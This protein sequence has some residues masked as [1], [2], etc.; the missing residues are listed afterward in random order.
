[1]EIEWRLMLK[2]IH[3]FF[4]FPE[5]P[6]TTKNLALNWQW[7]SK[8]NHYFVDIFIYSYFY[9]NADKKKYLIFFFACDIYKDVGLKT[10][11]KLNEWKKDIFFK[12]NSSENETQINMIDVESSVILLTLNC[13]QSIRNTQNL[14]KKQMKNHNEKKFNDLS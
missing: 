8:R 9:G 10:K 14:I 1:M 7:L 11:T 12:W 4:C 2:Y 6:P 3:N 5:L 13:P